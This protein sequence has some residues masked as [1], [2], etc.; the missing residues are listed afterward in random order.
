ML[1]ECKLALTQNNAFGCIISVYKRH[2]TLSFPHWNLPSFLLCLIYVVA[3]EVGLRAVI[4]ERPIE[5]ENDQEVP[6][7]PRTLAYGSFGSFIQNDTRAAGIGAEM[8]PNS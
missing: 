6:S 7:K 5:Q 4:D 1:Y 2:A 8:G 3:A